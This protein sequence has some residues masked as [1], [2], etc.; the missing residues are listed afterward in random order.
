VSFLALDICF[1]MRFLDKP[2]V[3]KVIQ[4]LDKVVGDLKGQLTLIDA[5]FSFPYIK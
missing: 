1:K 2:A 3:Q 4:Y 5:P